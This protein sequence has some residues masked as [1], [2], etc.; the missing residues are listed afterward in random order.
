M[1]SLG[2]AFSFSY[3]PRFLLPFR[4]QLLFLNLMVSLQ[5]TMIRYLSSPPME[6]LLPKS[7][8][9][10]L[11]PDPMVTSLCSFDSGFSSI[12]HNYSP[13][14]SGMTV[15]TGI[16]GYRALLVLLQPQRGSWVLSVSALQPHSTQDPKTLLSW[17]LPG[18]SWE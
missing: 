17:K 13:L 10:F 18:G 1:P 2:P 4:A 3:C 12:G 6:T 5:L 11:L 14:L 8:A 7:A 15:F 9:I 16:P